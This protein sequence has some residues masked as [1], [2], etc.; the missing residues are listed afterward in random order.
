MNQMTNDIDQTIFDSKD[1]D[2]LVKH[3]DIYSLRHEI[4]ASRER[5]HRTVDLEQ[6]IFE[7]E[8]IKACQFAIEVTKP[9]NNQKYNNHTES[10]ESIKQSYDLAEYI[11]RYIQ[12][13]K[14]GNKFQGLCP[15]HS[16]SKSPSFFIY[17]NNTYHCFGC[18]AHGTIID[19]V[20]HYDNLDIKTVLNKLSRK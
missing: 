5:L 12:L 11:G 19:F 14:S 15:F 2:Y 20:M 8:Y 9:D 6:Q 1:I 3:F 4:K 16:D 13:R 10:I 7:T 18:L 17:P